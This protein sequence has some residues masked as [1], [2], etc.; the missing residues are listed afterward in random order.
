M[1]LYDGEGTQESDRQLSRRRAVVLIGIALMA[2]S[3]LVY[4]F[5]IVISL[6][7]ISLKTKAT[8]TIIA[9]ATSWGVKGVGV[10]CAGKEAYQMVKR[11]FKKLFFGYEQF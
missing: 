8:L 11:R 1:A 6:L 5:Y 4:P 3:F 9:C 7:T 10:L 2:G